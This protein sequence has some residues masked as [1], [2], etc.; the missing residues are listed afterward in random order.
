MARQPPI[1]RRLDR[2]QHF[3]RWRIRIFVCV[4]FDQPV[5]F[6]LFA[7]HIGVQMLHQRADQ[8]FGI[9]QN[10]PLISGENAG[11]VEREMI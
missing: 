3:G 9:R 2:R 6:R 10:H 7:R 4:E 1:H 11:K 5:D 8:F